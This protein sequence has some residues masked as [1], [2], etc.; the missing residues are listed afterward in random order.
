M[1]SANSDRNSTAAPVTTDQPGQSEM[2]GSDKRHQLTV[3][4]PLSEDGIRSHLEDAMEAVDAERRVAVFNPV[5]SRQQST[6]VI[7]NDISSPAYAVEKLEDGVPGE[8]TELSKAGVINY[9]TDILGADSRDCGGE[10]YTKSAVGGV[11]SDGDVII[12]KW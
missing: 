10:F 3:P 6:L 12:N 5:N 8:T 7:T 11:T 1:S 9:L 4:T 2:A